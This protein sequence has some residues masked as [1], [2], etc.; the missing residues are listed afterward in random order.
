MPLIFLTRAARSS[1]NGLSMAF[2]LRH[3]LSR[4]YLQ[5]DDQLAPK[6]GSTA[7]FIYME[8]RA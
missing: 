2:D 8:Q 6:N 5:L 7:R 3:V 4:E 1:L